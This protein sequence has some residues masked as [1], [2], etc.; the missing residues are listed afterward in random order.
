MARR[1]AAGP[2]PE[3]ERISEAFFRC[4]TRRPAPEESERL[5]RL[6]RDERKAAGAA[7]PPEAG[8]IA[9]ARVL[10]NLDE[11]LTRE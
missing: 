5:W 9:V 11:T 3:R 1:M 4:T 2:G 7:A 10:L 6:L 8:W